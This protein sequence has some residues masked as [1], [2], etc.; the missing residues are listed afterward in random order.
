MEVHEINRSK[1]EGLPRP[2]HSIPAR[3]SP[4]FAQKYRRPVLRILLCLSKVSTAHLLIP[5]GRSPLVLNRPP[6]RLGPSPPLLD[7]AR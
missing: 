2:I 7:V 1:I 3:S 4:A 6:S 5:A